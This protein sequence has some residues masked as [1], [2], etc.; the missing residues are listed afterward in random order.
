[1]I[2]IMLLLAWPV[3]SIFTLFRLAKRSLPETAKALWV[4]LVIAVPLLGA[5]AFWIVRPGQSQTNQA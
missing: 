5:V 1:V 3:L 2:N 4:I